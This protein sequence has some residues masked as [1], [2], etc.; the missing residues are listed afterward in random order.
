MVV[1][2]APTPRRLSRPRWLNI[3]VVGGILLVVAAVVVG[4]RVIGASSQTSAVWAAERNLAAGTVL[5]G[6]DLTAVEVNLGDNSGL[7]LGP[8]GTS[9][10]G[11]TVLT[12]IAAGELLPASAIDRPSA[13]RVVAI[14]VAPEN[15]PPGV[16]H[17]STIDLYLTSGG[18]AGSESEATTELVG[19]DLTVQSVT[20]PS[21]GGLSGATSN[22]FALSVLLPAAAADKLV[23]VLPTGEP[24][25]VLVSPG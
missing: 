5:V 25:V 22:R 6:T 18:V 3:R 1:P 2:S 8:A 7:Y 13:G 12:P 20:A 10:V 4:A 9:P 11:M 21:S 24:I 16:D 15:M 23:R 19:R 17:G 14:A